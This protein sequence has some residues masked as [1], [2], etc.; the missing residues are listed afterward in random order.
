MNEING[1]GSMEAWVQV[2]D[3][4]LREGK[5]FKDTDGRVFRQLLNVNLVIDRPEKDI[6][7]PINIISRSE[8]WLYPSIDEIKRIFL[9]KKKVPTYDF[10][11]GQRLFNFNNEINQVDEF[12]IPFLKDKVKKNSRRLYITPWNPLMDSRFDY[13]KDMP[14]IVGIWFKVV[15][16]KLTV[17]AIIRNN[18]CFVGFP[19]NL[20]QIYV[21]QKYIADKTGFETGKIVFYSLSMHVYMD[22]LDDI[23]KLLGV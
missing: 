2:V 1:K 5:D 18:D 3:T 11:Y 16:D 17:T 22:H 10:T 20:Y 14:G 6:T 21:I 4:I 15:D 7:K 13:K 23:K 9:M 12:V 8:K 19:A